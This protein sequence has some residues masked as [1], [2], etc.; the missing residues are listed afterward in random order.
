[1]GAFLFYTTEFGEMTKKD[2]KSIKRK[3]VLSG[4]PYEKVKTLIGSVSTGI[5]DLGEKHR[6]HLL[7][8]LKGVRNEADLSVQDYLKRH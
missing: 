7:R 8:K 1:M 6:K 2:K 5:S 4:K 3:I